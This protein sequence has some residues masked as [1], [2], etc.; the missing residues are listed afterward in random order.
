MKMRRGAAAAAAT[1]SKSLPTKDLIQISW[2]GFLKIC[3]DA[4]NNAHGS[5]RSTFEYSTAILDYLVNT[6]HLGKL[7]FAKEKQNYLIEVYIGQCKTIYTIEVE[8]SKKSVSISLYTQFDHTLC[9]RATHNSTDTE[10]TIIKAQVLTEKDR[11]VFDFFQKKLLVQ[12]PLPTLATNRET[13]AT[14]E[15]STT[16]IEKKIAVSPLKRK[17]TIDHDPD[18]SFTKKKRE[19]K[20]EQLVLPTVAMHIPVPLAVPHTATEH[21]PAPVIVLAPVPAAALAPAPAPALAPALATATAPAPAPAP[22]PVSVLVSASAPVIGPTKIKKGKTGVDFSNMLDHRELCQLIE[23]NKSETHSVRFNNI[24]YKNS[25]MLNPRAY[26]QHV[27]W[28]ANDG[29][30]YD[31]KVHLQLSDDFIEKKA[32]SPPGF[33]PSSW[34]FS[35]IPPAN[36]NR[37]Q[38]LPDFNQINAAYTIPTLKKDLPKYYN[39]TFYERSTPDQ[40]IAFTFAS[41]DGNAA[42]LVDLRKRQTV[43]GKQIFN[44]ARTYLFGLFP[45]A[46]PVLA[47][48]SYRPGVDGK[49]ILRLV[50]VI[51]HG[52]TF[53]QDIGNVTLAQGEFQTC[54]Y[55]SPIKQNAV[56]RETEI[57]ELQNYPIAKWYKRLP[58]K[59][60]AKLDLLF[61]K[62]NAGKKAQTIKSSKIN[63]KDFVTEIFKTKEL[64][65]QTKLMS[66]L[67]TGLDLWEEPI[68]FNEK[69]SKATLDYFKYLIHEVC[70]GSLIWTMQRPVAESKT[71]I[72]SYCVG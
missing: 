72:P 50:N 3:E 45:A 28:I 9:I 47:D 23:D 63:L 71:E 13:K 67:E 58:K 34:L 62:Y 69:P 43:P 55:A 16:K 5:G 37:R 68:V 70:W 24:F 41:R 25:C 18:P 11:V 32:D 39:L 19:Q 42:E 7:L 40:S 8:I 4:R 21:V 53:Y 29:K 6:K 2:E 30:A 10:P 52:K 48:M 38:T 54:Y 65:D 26:V 22:N 56:K 35:D 66:L 59:E 44:L 64:T 51:Q 12:A 1:E 27:N 46:I 61:K 15:S 20:E 49:I 31:I 60:K 33:I 14:L 17:A 36:I 57:R